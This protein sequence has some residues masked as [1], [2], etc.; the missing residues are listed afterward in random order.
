[1]DPLARYSRQ[2]LLEQIGRDGQ[3]RLISSA[4][5]VVGC[6]ALGT[7]IASTL[8]RAGVGRIKVVDRDYIELSNLQRQILFDEEDIA[9]GLP[10]A[11]AAAEKL[12]RINS[13]VHIEPLVTDLNPGNAERI[14]RNADLV[15]DATDNFETRLLINDVCIKQ[16]I[17]WVYG[18]VVAT[19]GMTMAIIPG[20]TPCFRCF[21]GQIPPP[22]SRPTCDTV[23]VLGPA[24]NMVAS[25]E[26]TEGLKLLL[27]K[28][29]ELHGTLLYVDAWA[30]TLEQ[31]EV[32]KRDA[33]CP[34]CDLGN[35]EF[36]EGRA[37]SSVTTLCGRDAIQIR[38]RG[39]SQVSLGELARRLAPAGEVTFNSHMLH[40]RVDSYELTVFPDSRAIIRG[41]TD[42]DV[43]RSLYA[44]YIGT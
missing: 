38:L 8:A 15:L 26:V 18:A 5:V 31:L 29:E 25:L 41:A 44:R 24:V 6:G 12:R 27:G 42:E 14:I 13:E 16:G 9:R 20:R 40:F 17:P 7:V 30:A 3:E 10:K 23:G 43:A 36:L 11:V 32:G 2:T 37:G 33:P 34:A 22:G 21:L 35:F 1:M 19:Y 28:L 39:Q 4:V